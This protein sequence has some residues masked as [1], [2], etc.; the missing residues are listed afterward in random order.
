M[1]KL[2]TS[3]QAAKIQSGIKETVRLIKKEQAYSV[4]LQKKDYLLELVT[5][6]QKL[7]VM[8]NTGKGLPEVYPK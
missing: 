7:N 1:N 2:P 8:L 4:D 5:H 6:L 3:W